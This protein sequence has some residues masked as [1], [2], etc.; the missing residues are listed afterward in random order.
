MRTLESRYKQGNS[1]INILVKLDVKDFDVF[2]RFEKQASIIM[3]KYDGR[4]ISAFETERN[5]DGSGQEVHI[6]EFPSEEAFG[7]Y[8]K[9]P[10]LADLAY[11]REQAISNTSVEVSLRIKDYA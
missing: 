11:L 7:N 3:G 10:A 4:I 9:D 6:L 2:D 8:R 5:S 1:V